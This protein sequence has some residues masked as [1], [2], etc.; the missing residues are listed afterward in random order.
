VHWLKVYQLPEA[1]RQAKGTAI[2][3]L[4]QL[5]EGEKVSTYVPVREFKS[6]MFITM[7]TKKGIVKRTP[8]DNFAN[9]R[10]G[11]ILALGLNKGDQL[12]S[13]RLTNGKTSIILAT[14]EG[15]AVRFMET[16]IRPMGRTAVGVRGIKIRGSDELI[17]MVRANEKKSILTVTKNGFG[18]RTEVSDYR[19]IKRGGVGVINIKITEKNGAVACI[20]SVT[21]DDGLMFIT[22]NGITIRM[23]AKDISTIGRNTQGVRVMR[24]GSDDELAAAAKVPREDEAGANGNC[25]SPKESKA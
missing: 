23:A 17:G 13:A 9:P 14:A 8:L 2:I 7:A 16:D 6:D 20:S 4:I 5:E 12:I 18:K 11:G 24:L 25:G 10:K 3:N 15:M 1:A 21:D 22:R 19:V